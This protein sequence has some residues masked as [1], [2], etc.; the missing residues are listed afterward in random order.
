MQGKFA[1]RAGLKLGADGPIQP[2]DV[3]QLAAAFGKATGV[4]EVHLDQR[5]MA[6]QSGLKRTV[7]NAC[8]LINLS[9]RCLRTDPA[10]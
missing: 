8:R 6:G 10:S 5:Q 2:V 3:G 9:G 1:L 4:F 7:I